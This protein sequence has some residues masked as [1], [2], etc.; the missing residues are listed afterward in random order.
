[1]DS[2]ITAQQGH[3][4]SYL[5][6]RDVMYNKSHPHGWLI[7]WLITLSLASISRSLAKASSSSLMM[8]ASCS[9]VVLMAS[10]IIAGKRIDCN[11]D[12]VA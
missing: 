6:N 7:A 1:M 12:S 5:Q 11:M 8:I 2:Q 10:L 9:A 4:K 3:I